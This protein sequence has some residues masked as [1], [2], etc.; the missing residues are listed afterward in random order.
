MSA[1]Q[2][3]PENVLPAFGEQSVALRANSTEHGREVVCEEEGTAALV[4]AENRSQSPSASIPALDPT[5]S[6]RFPLGRGTGEPVGSSLPSTDT[7]SLGTGEEPGT[8]Q[9]LSAGLYRFSFHELSERSE[10]PYPTDRLPQAGSS[11]TELNLA[12]IVDGLVLGTIDRPRPTVGRLAD[13]SH[14][15]YRGRTNGLAGESG[16]GKTW[17]ALASVAAELE[18]GNSCVYIDMEDSAEGIVSRLL[19]LGVEPEVLA[20]PRRFAY[21]QPEEAFKD[22]LRAGFWGLLQWMNPALV[23]LDS[24][25]E[26]MALEGIDP[27]SDVAVA[28]WFTRV[29]TAI[30]KQGPAVLLLDHLPKSDNTASSPIGSQ[31]KRAA[32]TGVQMIQTVP[33]QMAFAI[34]RAGQAKLTCTKDRHGNFV[35]G[36]TAALL[37]VNPVP[38]RGDTAVD[39]VLSRAVEGGEPFAH[40]RVMLRISE[41]LETAGAAQSTNT[42]VREV[43][44]KRA[45]VIDALH[46]LEASGYVT[47]V[48]GARNATLF[49]LVQPFALGGVYTLPEELDENAGSVPCAHGW[50][51]GATRCDR[52][53]CHDGHFGSCNRDADGSDVSAIEAADSVVWEVTDVEPAFVG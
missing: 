20:N 12:G 19:D 37:T 44:G 39:V 33:S 42:I 2:S 47:S 1:N 18:D 31:R 36:E 17:T 8:G 32:I 25:G 50:H 35:T 5:G 23:V 51:E 53:W 21:V 43:R 7:R 26:S 10:R 46:V 13:G 49:T 45:T 40:T 9:H 28:D 14:W 16:S 52:G 48:A 34:G 27:N 30:A 15:L 29:A 3:Q 4:P 38:S 6:D 22:D 11:W 24:T 41:F